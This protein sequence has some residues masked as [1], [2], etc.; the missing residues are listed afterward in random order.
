M[1]DKDLK[2]LSRAELVEILCRQ[3]EMIDELNDAN[4]QLQTRAKEAESRCAQY[5]ARMEEEADRQAADDALR[6]EMRQAIRK[7]DAMSCAV[8]HCGEADRRLAAAE[9]EAEELL[10]QA[11][12]EAER[13]RQ[14]TLN[15]IEQRRSA[16]TRQ[17][18]ELL[19]GQ[20]MLRRL[21]EN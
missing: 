6:E 14:D 1:T 8:Q 21:M 12:G 19:R 2:K 18:E 16:F 17:C 20:E 15:E 5:A 11:R 7:I 13:L 9:K 10:E 3:R 4:R